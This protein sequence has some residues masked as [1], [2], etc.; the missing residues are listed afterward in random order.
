MPRVFLFCGVGVSV[1]TPERRMNERERERILRNREIARM[2]GRERKNE[3]ERGWG[4][5]WG[6]ERRAGR[7]IGERH[8][9]RAWGPAGVLNSVEVGRG[10]HRGNINCDAE[11]LYRLGRVHSDFNTHPRYERLTR[12][13]QINSERNKK[14]EKDTDPRSSRSEFGCPV[15]QCTRR[16]IY[17]TRVHGNTNSSTQ[18]TTFTHSRALRISTASDVRSIRKNL[19]KEKNA[20]SIVVN[21]HVED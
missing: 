2:N 6:W 19:Y 7:K 20:L 9:K 10:F 14:K 13:E 8:G 11:L 21:T 16:K 17:D 15:G 4:W 18:N 5:R 1:W 3:W 12:V